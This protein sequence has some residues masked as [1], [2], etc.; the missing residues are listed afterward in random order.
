LPSSFL[1]NITPE[2]LAEKSDE[3]N[4]RHTNRKGKCQTTRVQRS[5][6]NETEI[7]KKG[8]HKTNTH[9]FGTFFSAGLL[10]KKLTN[11]KRQSPLKALPNQ[12]SF[13]QGSKGHL[14]CN[15]TQVKLKRQTKM[16]RLP[17][18]MSYKH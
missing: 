8:G 1:S 6:R 15:K 9:T 14:H 12:K 16:K 10:R 2:V 11:L 5:A 18:F 13:S 4:T 7:K 17:I 3:C